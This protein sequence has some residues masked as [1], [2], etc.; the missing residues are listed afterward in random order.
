MPTYFVSATNIINT[1]SDAND[2]LD[3][4]GIQ[5]IGGS[6]TYNNSTRVLSNAA[7]IGFLNPLVAYVATGVWV[8]VVSGTGWTKGLYQ[9]EAVDD[10]NGTIT[11][12]AGQSGLGTGTPTLS[13]GPLLTFSAAHGKVPG[14]V[15]G[16]WTNYGAADAVRIAIYGTQTFGAKFSWTAVGAVGFNNKI[17]GCDAGGN[18]GSAMGTLQ[19][20]NAFTT[21]AS[22]PVWQMNSASNVYLDVENIVFNAASPNNTK[23]QYACDL[24]AT[25]GYMSMTNCEFKNAANSGLREVSNRCALI[26]CRAYGNANF[27]FYLTSTGLV[28]VLCYGCE[29][30]GNTNDGFAIDGTS[31]AARLVEC[32]AHNNGRHGFALSTTAQSTIFIGCVSAFNTQH[33]FDLSGS[34]TAQGGYVNLIGCVSVGNGSTSSHRQFNFTGTTTRTNANILQGNYAGA[35]GSALNYNSGSDATSDQIYAG[36][37]DVLR[38]TGVTTF[39]GRLKPA[40]AAALKTL[41]KKDRG[42]STVITN[43]PGLSTPGG[44]AAVGDRVLN[45]S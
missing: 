37:Y 26:R 22:N 36:S 8:A 1:A 13:T 4:F 40:Q 28:S 2:G 6:F 31:E 21:P 38:S 20:T 34:N 35:N 14:S 18:I 23:C 16:P 44:S 39:D 29:A 27:G 32:L 19:P 3:L 15:T 42:V 9:L 30:H 17:T 45:R 10:T 33:G 24:N 25:L 43:A 12:K 41:V 11:F 5:A 7:M